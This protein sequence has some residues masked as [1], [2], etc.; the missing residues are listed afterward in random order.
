[1]TYIE[2]RE[3]VENEGLPAGPEVARRLTMQSVKPGSDAF[4]EWTQARLNYMKKRRWISQDAEDDLDF[5]DAT[6]STEH[7]LA[8][9]DRGQMLIGMRLT[10]VDSIEQSMSWGMVRETEI[11]DEV[12]QNGGLATGAV[13]DLT[14]LVPGPHP[15]RER[16]AA[17]DIPALFDEGLKYC[18]TL[19]D[20]NPTWV[21]VLDALTEKWLRGQ[22]VRVE[23][24]A[25]PQKI[26]GDKVASVLATIQPAVISSQGEKHDFAR[27]SF[28]RTL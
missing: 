27:R 21:F 23:Y 2:S 26:N 24:L 16:N 18:R 15:H 4:I 8:Y 6:S 7:I 28:R 20:N 10:P 5:Y 9:D 12:R 22:D 25:Q 11:G 1:M 17:R 14:R 13:W 3:Q 19:G